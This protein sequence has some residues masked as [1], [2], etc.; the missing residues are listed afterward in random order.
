[1]VLAAAMLSM[2]GIFPRAA[3]LL[4]ALVS[5]PLALGGGLAGGRG[6]MPALVW[7]FLAGA[8]ACLV[9]CIPLPFGLL[10]AVAPLNADVWA[11][12]VPGAAAPSFATL[13]LAPELTLV[14]AAKWA[15]YAG[16]AWLGATWTRRHGASGPAMVVAGLASLAGIVTV[17]HGVLDAKAVF[18][19][20]RPITEFPRWRVGPFL[21]ANHLSGYLSLG[22]FGALGALFSRRDR[23][24]PLA[25]LFV[26]QAG[27]LALGVFLLGSRAAVPLLVLGALVALLTGVRGERFRAVLTWG[28]WGLAVLGVVGASVAWLLRQRIAVAIGDSGTT[29]L[30][31]IRDALSMAGAHWSFGV[32]RGAFETSFFAFKT[33]HRNEFWP[34]PENV[35]AQWTS[36]WGVPIS[37][38]LALGLVAAVFTARRGLTRST[39]ARILVVGLGVLVAHNMVDSSLELF[40]VGALAAFA[41]GAALGVGV[42]DDTADSGE[43]APRIASVFIAGVAVLALMQKPESPSAGRQRGLLAANEGAPTAQASLLELVHRFPADPWYPL[44]LAVLQGRARPLA[45]IA[46]YNRALERGPN[47]SATHVQLAV[48]LARAGRRAQSLL[49][50]RLAVERDDEIAEGAADLAAIVARSAEEAES[51]APTSGPATLP[52]LA[53]LSTSGRPWAREVRDHLL[54]RDPCFAPQRRQATQEAVAAWVPGREAAVEA[55]LAAM[56]ACPDGKPIADSARSD[57]LWALGKQNESLDLLEKACTTRGGDELPR[58]LER[59]AERSA[60]RKDAVRVRRAVRLAVSQRCGVAADCGAAW[61]WAAGVYQSTGDDPSAQAAATK[62]TEVDPAELS[63]WRLLAT[64]S[65]RMGARERA[66]AAAQRVLVRQPDDAVARGIIE[67]ARALPPRVPPRRP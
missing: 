67:A 53:R 48:E 1:V 56:E 21:N 9:Q 4:A 20:Y 45:G 46:W 23:S 64:I 16:L 22:V 34:Q 19:V 50:I 49:E 43:I 47:L 3:A 28:R 35:V 24:S 59:L 2:G 38:L 31:A 54:T 7:V 60:E 15:G 30:G 33:V 42:V 10:T 17:L 40:G 36:E 65:M 66:V 55:Q 62:A 6:R 44:G 41:L 51:A 58:C 5:V 13:S 12:A 8:L 63:H 37:V 61:A 27:G 32:G 25:G 14:E 18:G 52:F 29:K 26:V 11:R 57:F 39:S